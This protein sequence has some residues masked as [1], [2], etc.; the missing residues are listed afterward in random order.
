MFDTDLSRIKEF[1]YSEV[2]EDSLKISLENFIRYAFI[3]YSDRFTQIRNAHPREVIYPGTDSE[4]SLLVRLEN[5]R[6]DL[7]GLRIKG[8]VGDF[9]RLIRSL[10]GNLTADFSNLCLGDIPDKTRES[11]NRKRR[12]NYSQIGIFGFYFGSPESDNI[13]RVVSE[14]NKGIFKKERAPEGI[15]STQNPRYVFGMKNIIKVIS[16]KENPLPDSM[17]ALLSK[18]SKISIENSAYVDDDSEKQLYH[19][20]GI[21]I[22]RANGEYLLNYNIRTADECGLSSSLLEQLNSIFDLVKKRFYKN[23][24]K[25]LKIINPLDR[26][27]KGV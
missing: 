7:Y 10:R 12:G 4:L 5:E 23:S 13:K 8:I 20:K 11:L 1:F 14:R 15:G 6:T 18:A 25:R 24:F 27:L 17:R 21:I 19:E 9:S 26:R 2:G 22:N 16:K 3:A